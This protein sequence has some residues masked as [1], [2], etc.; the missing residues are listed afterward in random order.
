MKNVSIGRLISL[1]GILILS[2]GLICSGFELVSVT[3]FRIIVLVGIV[4]QAIALIVIL[5]KKE[6]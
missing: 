5:K 1:L 4:T 6:F 3:V 2:V